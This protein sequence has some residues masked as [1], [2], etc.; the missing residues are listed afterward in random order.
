MPDSNG[1]TVNVDLF[2][3]NT[4]S[5]DRVDSLTSEGFVDLEEIDI[6]LAQSG[7]LQH[8]GNSIGGTDTHDAWGNADYGC[9]NEFADDG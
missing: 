4:N 6:V 2:I 7:A 3:R 1:T 9:E 8:F 5:V